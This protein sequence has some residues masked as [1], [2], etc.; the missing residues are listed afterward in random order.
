MR[1]YQ[2]SETR[3]YYWLRT[4]ERTRRCLR[5]LKHK[6]ILEFIEN[7]VDLDLF[8]VDASAIR[9]GKISIIYV[10]RLV[11]YKRVDLLLDACEKLIGKIDFQLHIV[12]DGRLRAALQKQVNQLSLTRHV[13]FHGWLPQAA[14]AEMLRSS[15][16]MAFPSMRECGGAVVLEAMAS[17]IPVI[18]AKVGW[19]S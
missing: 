19:P 13:Q 7:G 8:R 4:K 3:R 14:V 15:D 11:D 18:A 16:I 9:H 6:K 10:G 2:A 5:I 12:G 17:G 1:L